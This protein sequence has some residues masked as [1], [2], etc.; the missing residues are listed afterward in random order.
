MAR[1]IN[2][3]APRVQARKLR[4]RQPETVAFGT[5]G[6]SGAAK[7]FGTAGILAVCIAVLTLFVYAGVLRFDF[8]GYDDRIYVTEN[9][10]IKSGLSRDNAVWALTAFYDSNWF[11]LTLISHMA[12]VELYGLRPG[13]HHM[14]NVLFHTANS[15][16]LFFL[17]RRLLASHWMSAFI[18]VVFAL[19]PVHVESVA[20]VSE[21][22]DVLS[23]F[24]WIIAMLSYVRYAARPKTAT[25]L[26]VTIFF[27]L[28]LMTKPMPVTL[29][30]VLLLLDYWPLG[31]MSGVS[32][33]PRPDCY[34]ARPLKALIAEKVPLFIISALSAIV[35][36]IAQK[37]G[38]SVVSLQRLP[39][40]FRLENAVISYVKYIFNTIF[41]Y[42]LSILYLLPPEIPPLQ[43]IAA[44]AI[45]I[46]ISIA[47]IGK[48]IKLPY[49]FTGWF[50]FLGTLVPVI[51]LVQ[52]GGQAMA[53]RYNYMP[54]VGLFIIAAVGVP[55][56]L[57]SYRRNGFVIAAAAALLLS[58]YIVST[59]R[60][61]QYWN[62]SITLFKRA[63]DVTTGNKVAYYNL[64]I[65]YAEM[66]R[67]DDAIK[68][69]ENALR[70]SPA[71]CD[72]I[73]NLGLALM[74]KGLPD[75]AAARFKRVV[76]INQGYVKSYVAYGNLLLK[77]NR[78]DEAM[79][80]YKHAIEINPE[81]PGALNGVGVVMALT[82]NPEGALEMFDKALSINPDYAE[83]AN[84]KKGA[85]ALIGKRGS[86]Q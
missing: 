17:F 81:L 27:V 77:Q 57:K 41:P 75:E 12:D 3:D 62:N 68:C 76:E 24:F 66:G 83:A 47:A 42:K 40:G 18:A 15:V 70:I 10:H 35:T 21:R 8:V 5:A 33:Q 84:N 36:L 29:P 63:I 50:W 51:G 43:A 56:L 44:A 37:S 64:G 38:N 69:Y 6:A 19:H 30:F 86:K 65:I 58:F 79:Q 23:A 80:Q 2:G 72:T 25:Y 4:G 34:E 85:L 55:A 59:K 73:H 1:H 82:G 60:Q 61:L 48:A 20:W 53:D 31:R 45:V 49:L 32:P 78:L 22:K 39:F 9:A 67:Y 28:G 46:L 7:A 74:N 14:N 52:V 11:P 54:S 16:L 26:L 13:L 71:D